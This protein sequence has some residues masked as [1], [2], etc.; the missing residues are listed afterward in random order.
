MCAKVYKIVLESH[1]QLLALVITKTLKVL[2]LNLILAQK[3]NFF[4]IVHC[5]LL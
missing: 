3:L 4:V 2:N 1:L 5:A